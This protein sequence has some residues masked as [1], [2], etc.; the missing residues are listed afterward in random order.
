MA[1]AT[2][3]TICLLVFAL[4]IPVG[5]STLISDD[6]ET[7]LSGTY[8]SPLWQNMFSGTSAFVSIEQALSGTQS[9]RTECT[10]NWARCDYVVLPDI[11]DELE[12]R[13][14]VFLTAAD[15]GC[16]V[17]FGFVEPGTPNTGRIANSIAFWNNGEIYFDPLTVSNTLIGSWTT[18]KWYRVRVRINYV[19]QLATVYLDGALAAE[20]VSTDPDTIPA[21]VYGEAVPLNQ[22][23]LSSNNFSGGGTSVLFYDDVIIMDGPF[24]PIAPSSWGRIKQLYR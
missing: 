23:C 16:T 12:Y 15:R 22:F 19:T 14:A 5:A 13:A 10:Y 11:P 6:F 24:T 4:V 18:G 21:A 7:Y 20:D 8:P 9:L 1:R 2:M 17:G 3:L